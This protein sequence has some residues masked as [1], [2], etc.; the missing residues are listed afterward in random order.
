MCVSPTVSVTGVTPIEIRGTE[1]CQNESK[2]IYKEN[3]QLY[4]PKLGIFLFVNP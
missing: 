1:K 3:V 2:I 4:R